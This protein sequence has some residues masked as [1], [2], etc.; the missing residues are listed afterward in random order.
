MGWNAGCGVAGLYHG[1]GPNHDDVQAQPS[2]DVEMGDSM[3]D[4]EPEAATVVAQNDETPIQ[5]NVGD[6]VTPEPAQATD[7]TT[8]PATSTESQHENAQSDA[9][10]VPPI[11]VGNTFDMS[12]MQVIIGEEAP[13]IKIKIKKP[14]YDDH[15]FYFSRYLFF[16]HEHT[17]L[18]LDTM[19]IFPLS[20]H[21]LR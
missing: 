5:S 6:P 15:E 3:A 4:T 20:S 19:V 13:K 7:A 10:A 18:S 2:E 21:S 17:L 9:T 14:H 16:T 11:M 12:A 8:E 1:P